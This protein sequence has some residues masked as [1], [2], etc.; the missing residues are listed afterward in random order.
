MR[1]READALRSRG[2]YVYSIG[3]GN[4]NASDPLLVPDMD[5]LRLLANQDG[6]ADA[7][8]PRGNAYFAPTAA[9]LDAVFSQVAADLLVRLA[10]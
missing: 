7:D 5:Y 1:E 6:I 2:I 9:D 4:P 8:Q 3:L 10:K